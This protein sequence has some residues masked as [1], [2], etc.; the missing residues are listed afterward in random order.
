[1]AVTAATHDLCLDY[2]NTNPMKLLLTLLLL[3]E[4]CIVIAGSLGKAFRQLIL[5]LSLFLIAAANHKGKLQRSSLIGTV[6]GDFAVS[7]Q[8]LCCTGALHSPSTAC[9]THSVTD[10][11]SPVEL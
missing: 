10:F 6:P 11:Y 7:D 4:T 8:V 9:M 5:T 1:M 3:T 2:S